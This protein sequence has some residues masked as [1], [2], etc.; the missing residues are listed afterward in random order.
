MDNYYIIIAFCCGYLAYPFISA[1]RAIYR[2]AFKSTKND[3]TVVTKEPT[4]IVDD[5]TIHNTEPN[6]RNTNPKVKYK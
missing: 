5:L 1:C 6:L 4:N 2:N 3:E